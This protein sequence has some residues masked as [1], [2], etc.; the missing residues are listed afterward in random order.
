MSD[1]AKIEPAPIGEAHHFTFLRRL[2][3]CVFVL[4]ALDAVF[5]LNWVW[6]GK[7]EEANPLI[8]DLVYHQPL[9]FIGVKLTLVALGSWLLWRLRRHPGAVVAI[10]SVFLVYYWL[11]LFHLHSVEFAFLDGLEL[12][13]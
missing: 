7:A 5:T 8:A 12:G 4:N 1:E 2:V 13:M 9:V 6:A 10:F 3:L 11:L